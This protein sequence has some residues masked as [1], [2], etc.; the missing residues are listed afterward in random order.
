M[1]RD[2]GGCDRQMVIFIQNYSFCGG[3]CQEL[4]SA[5]LSNQETTKDVGEEMNPGEEG[6]KVR[7]KKEELLAEGGRNWPARER[8]RIGRSSRKSKEKIVK[9]GVC[10]N[11][12]QHFSYWGAASSNLNNGVTALNGILA[13]IVTFELEDKW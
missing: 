3:H 6:E 11:P 1:G 7:S 4:H 8:M 5:I 12:K 9:N 10:T 2:K 13:R